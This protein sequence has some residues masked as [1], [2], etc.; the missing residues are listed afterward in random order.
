MRADDTINRISRAPAFVAFLIA[1]A[2]AFTAAS[3]FRAAQT[4]PPAAPPR[5]SRGQSAAEM[6]REI[7]ELAE[8]FGPSATAED[9]PL[10]RLSD[11]RGLAMAR[12]LGDLLS[13]PDAEIRMEAARVLGVLRYPSSAHG[14]AALLFDANEDVRLAACAALHNLPAGAV[15]PE[16]HAVLKDFENNLD[17]AVSAARLF[18]KFADKD[19]AAAV[20]PWLASE[21]DS[22]RK[23][24]IAALGFIGADRLCGGLSGLFDC[25]SEDVRL[26]AA[27]IAD[28]RMPEA[29]DMLLKFTKSPSAAMRREVAAALGAFSASRVPE[30]LIEL[31]RDRD[32]SVRQKALWSFIKAGG[33]ASAREIVPML[34]DGDA[35]V[36]NVAFLALSAHGDATIVPLVEDYA[37]NADAEV[38]IRA[39]DLLGAI[40]AAESVPPLEKMLS[41][42]SPAVR[43]RALAAIAAAGR[44]SAASSVTGL[45]SSGGAEI[46]AQ[47]AETLGRIRA[48][49]AA[50]RL[51]ALLRDLD[52]PVRSAATG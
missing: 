25:S 22:L 36:A 20:A 14:L 30:A 10:M 38:R 21:N 29:L 35:E 33:S 9:A 19:A 24:A 44:A 51:A 31:A 28:P 4:A 7:L 37:R 50:P 49:D 16:L 39:A 34:G 3:R 12:F 42:E 40:G 2:A 46:R 5:E 17:A 8:R 48:K 43:C 45:L 15:L 27:A 26:A 47:A 32:A 52:A 13:H 6:P 18:G 41:D 11:F 1:G 23:E